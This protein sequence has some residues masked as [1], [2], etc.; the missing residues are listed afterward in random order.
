[1]SR[2]MVSVATD[3]ESELTTNVL[4]VSPMLLNICRQPALS[5][6]IIVMVTFGILDV[7]QVL[8]RHLLSCLVVLVLY[9]R[10]GCVG[11]TVVRNVKVMRTMWY[12]WCMCG[13]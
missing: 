6:S 9:V 2:R 10:V 11:V 7:G 3:P 12:V 5:V 8:L 1:M 4:L 13:V